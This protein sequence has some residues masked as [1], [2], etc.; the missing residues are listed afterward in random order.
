MRHC[1]LVSDAF[2]VSTDGVVDGIFLIVLLRYV[3]ID[4]V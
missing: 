1:A 3:M 2:D 4:V